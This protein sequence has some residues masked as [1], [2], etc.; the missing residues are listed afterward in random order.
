[1]ARLGGKDRGL[2]E[3]PKGSNTWW[4]RWTDQFGREHREKVGSKS[5]ALK[6][7]TK[8]KEDARS[9]KVPRMPEYTG[10][11]TGRRASEKR[12]ARAGRF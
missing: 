3:R 5:N 6:V 11:R 12:L 1:M 10:T 8:R 2:F 7:Y 9:E 4:I